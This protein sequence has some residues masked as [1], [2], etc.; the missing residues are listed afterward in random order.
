[1]GKK[2]KLHHVKD[3]QIHNP[4]SDAV[5][6][7]PIDTRR[8]SNLFRNSPL[9]SCKIHVETEFK[10]RK[11]IDTTTLTENKQI[12]SLKLIYS[13][14]S[15]CIQHVVTSNDMDTKGK[16]FFFSQWKHIDEENKTE[17][18]FKSNL[19][20][21]NNCTQSLSCTE[22]MSKCKRSYS[23]KSPLLVSPSDLSLE[24]ARCSDLIAQMEF[25]YIKN[26]QLS[27]NHEIIRSKISLLEK[28]PIGIDALRNDLAKTITK[29]I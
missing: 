29:N 23:T 6:Q 9:K 11:D 12:S 1:M 22:D 2:R 5:H 13:Q 3:C 8:S 18:R 4:I 21:T 27:I 15:C 20:H 17:D 28:L 7:Q 14:N 26:I 25:Q 19:M 10:S 24:M 16:D